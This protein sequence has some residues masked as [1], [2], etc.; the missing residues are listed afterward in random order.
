MK[1]L[2]E[3]PLELQHLNLQKL[4]Y[5]GNLSLLNKRKVTILGSRNPNL[6]AQHFTQEIAK[7]ISQYGM[8]VVSGGALGIDI[9]AHSF[10]LPLTIM[11]APSSLDIIYPKTN[12][13]MIQRMYEQSLVLSQFAPSYQPKTYSFLERNKLVVSLGECIILPQANL[14]SGSMQSAEYALSLKKKI[15]VIPHRLGESEGTEYLAK[16]GLAE[17]I[18]N[19]NEF[20]ESLFGECI[21]AQPI[22]EILEFCRHN[23]FF[24]EALLKFGDRI[25]EYE[26][27]GKIR[28]NNGR[29]EVV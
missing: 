9:I 27:E 17:V 8:V 3:I 22:D 6:Y 28:R 10:S 1:E 12:F 20:L 11:I 26:L 15:Y 25:F 19:V 2:F 7:K 4:Y 13:Q 29:V 18:W 14:K 24:E 23:P 16:E 21:Q 5:V